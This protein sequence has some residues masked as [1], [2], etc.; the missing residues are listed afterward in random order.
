MAEN[1]LDKV[2]VL[3]VWGEVAIFLVINFN[4]KSYVILYLFLFIL[5]TCIQCILL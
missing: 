3:S 4:L 2:N 1:L 5:V